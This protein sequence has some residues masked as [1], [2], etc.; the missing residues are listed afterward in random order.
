[1]SAM[2]KVK[3]A[4]LK[5]GF[6]GENSR[7]CAEGG[8]KT[9]RSPHVAMDFVRRALDAAAPWWKSQGAEPKDGE[10]IVNS[11]VESETRPTALG[12]G[13]RMEAMQRKAGSRPPLGE[14]PD[15]PKGM[16]EDGVAM[17]ANA[18]TK[19]A[20]KPAAAPSKKDGM[21]KV[22]NAELLSSDL[23]AH[24]RK[25][26]HGNYQGGK[27]NFRDK[28][29]KTAEQL[30]V[31]RKQ[32]KNLNGSETKA[33]SEEDYVSK[34]W[35]NADYNTPEFQAY[36][37][38]KNDIAAQRDAALKGA[39]TDEERAKINEEYDGKFQTAKFEFFTES[40]KLSPE[41]A[42]ACAGIA[43]KMGS[44][45]PAVA[46]AAQ[47]VV[48]A[49][50]ENRDGTAKPKEQAAAQAILAESEKKSEKPESGENP[51]PEEA[52]GTEEAPAPS[53]GSAS[54]GKPA[55]SGGDPDDGFADEL[56]KAFPD[57][58]QMIDKLSQN[59]D[60]L[61]DLLNDEQKKK[62]WE[63]NEGGDEEAFYKFLG[64]VGAFSAE[65]VSALRDLTD[66]YRAAN[67]ADYPEYAE[68]HKNDELL[69]R[70]KKADRRLNNDVKRGKLSGIKNRLEIKGFSNEE[71]EQYMDAMGLTEDQKFAVMNDLPVP[72]KVPTAEEMAQR[73]AEQ[74]AAEKMDAYRKAHDQASKEKKLDDPETAQKLNDLLKE[75]MEAK[76]AAKNPASTAPTAAPAQ[77]ATAPAEG[78]AS[79]EKAESGGVTES[80]NAP[81]P[82]AKATAEEVAA[83]KPDDPISEGTTP[84]DHAKV[85]KANPKSNCPFLK[86]HMSK[87]AL[88]ALDKPEGAQP[89]ATGE[90]AAPAPATGETAAEPSA[91]SVPPDSSGGETAT[92]AETAEPSAAPAA[93][94]EA[95]AEE[96][97]SL[98]EPLP[99][100][101]PPEGV[102]LDDDERGALDELRQ[103]YQDSKDPEEQE[104]L[105]VL[106]DTMT[107]ELQ[108]RANALLAQQQVENDPAAQAMEQK[109]P[110]FMQN[111]KDF[112]G[113]IAKAWKDPKVDVDYVERAQLGL[114]KDGDIRRSEYLAAK[115]RAKK[116]QDAA[117][118]AAYE[119]RENAKLDAAEKKSGGGEGDSV[120]ENGGVTAA[121]GEPYTPVADDFLN[122]EE[123]KAGGLKDHAAVEN[124]IK[125]ALSESGIDAKNLK[126][127][128]GIFTTE[129]KIDTGGKTLSSKDINAIQSKVRM[130]LARG[131][132]A[133]GNSNVYVSF[134]E[135]AG[136][137]LTV[138]V[139]HNDDERGNVSFADVYSSQKWKD[140]AKN[141]QVPFILGKD[142]KGQPIIGDMDKLTHLLVAGK[143]GSGKS[144]RLNTLLVSALMAKSP[145]DLKVMIV[146]PKRV[147]FSG[148]AND[149][150]LAQP[151]ATTKEEAG[152][153]FDWARQ[154]HEN[155][156]ALMEKV[157]KETNL[158]VKNIADY[159]RLANEGKIPAKFPQKI[160]QMLLLVDEFGELMKGSDKSTVNQMGSLAALARA[161]GI[162][163]VAATQRPD[164]NTIDGTTKSNFPATLALSVKNP[165]SAGVVG[166]EGADRLADK[167]PFILKDSNGNETKGN[168]AFISDGE[169]GSFQQRASERP[170][171]SSPAAR[172]RKLKMPNGI[173][174]ETTADGKRKYTYGGKEYVPKMLISNGKKMQVWVRADGSD[175]TFYTFKG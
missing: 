23:A 45:N 162:H 83:Q 104:A 66:A 122:R 15:T 72:P 26:H 170:Q 70:V 168:G 95:T 121:T 6:S 57:K 111:M 169:V 53:E 175:K 78:T 115:M 158:N 85:C 33:G 159:N 145:D 50:A 112:F 10:R 49:I 91:G 13:R 52:E 102:E 107:G 59:F 35:G 11:P 109:Q 54:A 165:A 119:A 55:E 139:K 116:K 47:E 64:D 9:P 29:A 156:M 171:Q 37:G 42:G 38:K 2:Q 126:S 12:A 77:E 174:M 46:A 160:P 167:G 36:E 28:V 88:A 118:L 69:A 94:K 74:A 71:I 117:R 132:D 19:D 62:F 99:E 39:K 30:G 22:T 146:D 84:E 32:I 173:E 100:Y 135:D 81:T 113:G 63:L 127:E 101:T 138:T 96:P 18:P 16:G 120:H 114:P 149:P 44:D 8:E 141:G 82:T 124:K 131:K 5:A 87:E 58:A 21:G 1:M 79:A 31:S 56:K 41:E 7:E 142:D 128:K 92:P 150:H 27:C 20:G 163:L 86:A 75:A 136:G 17:D 125:T 43:Q 105:K 97:G 130:A 153:L 40:L 137:D 24:D 110:G 90:T 147:E 129:F 161:S 48:Q 61:N 172:P 151:I 14:L 103:A 144:A 3:D 148:F 76:K 154:E 67:P 106:Y 4:L 157:N 108:S 166:V 51:A 152:K 65:E 140:A 123:S 143:T 25:Y 93:E 164:S 73:K 98:P 60:T 155:R 68:Q 34:N 134:D 89:A 133:S 80:G